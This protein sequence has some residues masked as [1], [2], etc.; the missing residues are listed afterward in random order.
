MGHVLSQSSWTLTIPDWHGQVQATV[1]GWSRN[2]PVTTPYATEYVLNGSW[3]SLPLHTETVQVTTTP[4][5]HPAVV[6]TYKAVAPY[7]DGSL[8]ST[9][10]TAG[11]RVLMA[12]LE[13]VA[14]QAWSQDHSLIS[15][16]EAQRLP[17]VT[18]AV[19]NGSQEVLAVTVE[20][21]QSTWTLNGHV[22]TVPSPYLAPSAAVNWMHATL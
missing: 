15:L 7:G 1:P 12:Q 2:G 21:G 8:S 20:D 5:L 19:S 18:L 4:T 11:A 6:W 10:A 9:Q 14:T 3:G 22:F 17:A 16:P 13:G